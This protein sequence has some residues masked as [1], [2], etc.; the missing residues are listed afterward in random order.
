MTK[1]ANDIMATDEFKDMLEVL[2]RKAAK[3]GL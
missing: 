1:S 3:S 2:K